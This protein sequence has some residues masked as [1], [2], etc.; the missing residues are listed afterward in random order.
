MEREE[1]SDMGAFIAK[2]EQ[3]AQYEGDIINLEGITV[4]APGPKKTERRDLFWLNALNNDW[5]KRNIFT[6][7]R[8][9]ESG[10]IDMKDFL[11]LLR[12]T[13]PRLGTEGQI[14]YFIDGIE[15]ELRFIEALSMAMVE[16][17]DV[18]EGPIVGAM[19]GAVGA[20]GAISITTRSI[21]DMPPTGRVY[22]NI[23]VFTPSGYQQPAEFYSPR[24]ETL[25]ARQSQVPDLRTTVFWKPDVVISE[26]HEEAVFE[27]YTSDVPTTYS[28][29]IE[30]LTDDGKI[31]RQ[32]EKIVVG[33]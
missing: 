17:I 1:E 7:E 8:I 26:E 24:Y 16:T 14:L 27:F 13:H 18:L 2:A 3:I 5:A 21:E 6:R 4:T 22:D 23:V 12:F 31:V 33:D 10:L 20:G 25:Q 15:L 9:E 30:G 29:V 11:R 19:L 28:V 32:V